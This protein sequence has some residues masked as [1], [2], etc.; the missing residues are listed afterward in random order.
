MIWCIYDNREDDFMGWLHRHVSIAQRQ[1]HPSGLMGVQSPPQ[2]VCGDL[3]Y[4]SCGNHQDILSTKASKLG[5]QVRIMKLYAT[6]WFAG[7][8]KLVKTRHGLGSA[9]NWDVGRIIFEM[10]TMLTEDLVWKAPSEFVS[11]VKSGSSLH[12][13]CQLTAPPFQAKMPWGIHF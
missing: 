5:Y 7:P 13:K 1:P 12:L 3:L 11:Q 10:M 8:L 9:P 4:I 6:L 2:M